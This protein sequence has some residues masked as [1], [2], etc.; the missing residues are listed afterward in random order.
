MISSTLTGMGC[1]TGGWDWARSVSKS[2]RDDHKL[3]ERLLAL[4]HAD[5][6]AAELREYGV[7]LIYLDACQTAQSMEDPKASVAA[8][9]L[10]E[11]VGSVVAMSHSVLVETAH[12]FVEPFYKSLAQG[13]ESEMRCWQGRSPSTTIPTASR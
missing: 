1:T 5:E 11:G 7:P 6:L 2:P 9:L 12:R 13:S 10:E 4:V 8:K 3:G